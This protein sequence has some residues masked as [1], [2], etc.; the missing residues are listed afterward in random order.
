MLFLEIRGFIIFL[1]VLS[2]TLIFN[3]ANGALKS[4]Q[5]SSLLLIV[6][7]QSCS[8]TLNLL[9]RSLMGGLL[10]CV[11]KHMNTPDLQTV[12]T[13]AFREELAHADDQ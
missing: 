9:G 13:C 7:L 5:C 4:L 1:I 3:M 8:L 6:S 2:L 12:E 11:N 10:H